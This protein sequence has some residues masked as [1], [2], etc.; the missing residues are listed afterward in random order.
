MSDSS[1]LDLANVRPGAERGGGSDGTRGPTGRE[2]AEYRVS[3][4]RRVWLVF[5]VLAILVLAASAGM[6]LAR[7]ELS[8]VQDALRKAE[9]R[10]QEAERKLKDAIADKEVMMRELAV[11]GTLVEKS[12][13]SEERRAAAEK[14]AAEL[15]AEVESLKAQLAKAKKPDGDADRLRTELEAVKSELGV[16]LVRLAEA[17]AELQRLRS[18]APRPYRQP[19]SQELPYGPGPGPVNPQILGPP[20]R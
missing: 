15:E 18:G 9:L 12:G 10:A 4:S 6:V 16:T 20:I 5:G 14:R 17:Q 3:V 7:G 11:Q 19:Y 8:G 13:K 2:V 1:R